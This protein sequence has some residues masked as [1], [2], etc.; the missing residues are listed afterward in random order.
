MRLSRNVTCETLFVE[1]KR[2]FTIQ[3]ARARKVRLTGFFSMRVALG[4]L[5]TIEE[6]T[7]RD[8]V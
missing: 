7:T 2:E 4:S 8:T 6:R 1:R 5:T 3:V